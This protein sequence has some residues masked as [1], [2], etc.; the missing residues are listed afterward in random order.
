MKKAVK[1]LSF[2]A[3][4]AAL[5]LLLP[6]FASAAGGTPSADIIGYNLIVQD[7]VY[8][9]YGVRFQNADGQNAGLLVWSSYQSDYTYAN[10]QYR[11]EPEGKSGDLHVF[12]FRNITIKQMTDD[13]YARAYV[14]KDGNF[15]YSQVKKYSILQ[16]AYNKLGYTGTRTDNEDLVSY[17]TSMLKYGARTQTYEN[18]HTERLASDAYS[19]ITTVGGTLPDGFNYGLYKQGSEISLSS[20]DSPASVKWCDYRGSAF[21]RTGDATY[22]VG[23][24]NETLTAKK[25]INIL[26]FGD[27]MVCGYNTLDL[28]VSF[29][30][31]DDVAVNKAFSICYNNLDPKKT[32]ATY[33]LYEL[34]EYSAMTSSGVVTG[35][36]NKML[37]N[38]LT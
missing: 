4:A 31:A 17:L 11:L 24:E 28:F 22:T 14:Q 1:L 35:V 2:L 36:K 6:V 18:Y 15:Y 19:K 16:Y 32:S 21:S 37:R 26:T 27:S 30:S 29:A 25:Q 8:I 3:V 34:L 33:N 10:A 23:T 38:A 5:F 20:N 12:E 7:N 9:S 13:F